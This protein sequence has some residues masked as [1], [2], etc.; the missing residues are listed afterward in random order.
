MLFLRI[1]WVVGQAG[2]GLGS[3]IILLASLVTILTAL[4]MSAISTNGEV[5]G[6]KPLSISMRY[7]TVAVISN[8]DEK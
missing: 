2:L 6:G 8:A 5:R 1:S 7:I 4:S 3:I